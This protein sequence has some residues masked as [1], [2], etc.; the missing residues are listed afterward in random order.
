M[1]AFGGVF[2]PI[3]KVVITLVC[4]C[5]AVVCSL[6]QNL[7]IFRHVWNLLY[8]KTFLVPFCLIMVQNVE[9][10]NWNV[11]L[12][13]DFLCRI[14][15]ALPFSSF[16]LFVLCFSVYFLLCSCSTWP[17]RSVYTVHT[18]FSVTL[19]DLYCFQLFVS[20]ACCLADIKDIRGRHL[21][22]QFPS[23]SRFVP[24][25][26]LSYHSLLCY[27]AWGSEPLVFSIH[28]QCLDRVTQ[29]V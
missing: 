18:N 14:F 27:T 28:L 13:G 16:H 25:F 3:H 4:I 8:I 2:L 21:D 12:P 6:L 19:R 24:C 1:S 9:E 29:N 10:R 15:L 23:R 26:P 7:L 20:A 22:I 11:L 5:T 17:L